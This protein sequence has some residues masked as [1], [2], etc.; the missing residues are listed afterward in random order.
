MDSFS[1]TD[2][3]DEGPQDQVRSPQDG[4]FRLVRPTI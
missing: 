1:L 4:A 3:D 2:S